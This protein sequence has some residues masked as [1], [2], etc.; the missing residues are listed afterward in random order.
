MSSSLPL[1]PLSQEELSAGTC[2]AITALQSSGLGE[3]EAALKLETAFAAWLDTDG[4]GDPIPSELHPLL[5]A[6]G[7]AGKLK[8]PAHATYA[9]LIRK[10]EGKYVAKRRDAAVLLSQLPLMLLLAGDFA[11]SPAR[12]AQLLGSM[13]GRNPMSWRVVQVVLVHFRIRNELDSELVEALIAEDEKAATIQFTDADVATILELF[14]EQSASFGL[15]A[16]FK[17]SLSSLLSPAQGQPFIPYLQILLYVSVVGHFYDHPPEYIY[18]FKP[19]GLVANLVF[20]KFPAQLAPGGN[21]ML[22]N[23][24]AL[25]RLTY[26]WAESREDNKIQAAALV[27][28]V[29]GLSSLSF[30]A[31]KQ[32]CGTIRRGIFRFVE[33][34]TPPE[35]TIPAA[36]DL[37]G[38]RTFLGNVAAEATGT[39]GII[40]QRVTDFLS[41]MRYRDTAWRARGLGDPVNASNTSSQKLGDCDFQ[42]AATHRY[43]AFK[44]HAG[45]LTDVYLE[46][47]LRTL[48]INLPKRKVEWS[49][50]SDIDEWSIVVTF[51]THE[52]ARSI[53]KAD[54]VDIPCRLMVETFSQ[55]TAALLDAV[56]DDPK[57]CVSFFN[58][59]VIAPLNAPNTPHYAKQKTLE[60]F[61]L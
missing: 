54:T 6:A 32:L 45:R 56:V 22:N 47:H 49:G 40:E 11:A 33:L 50:I 21:P 48:R 17:D 10:I 20:S 42:N 15:D 55:A 38:I 31:R 1:L 34:R 13:D 52:D 12:I 18:T 37:D 24:K 25:D 41:A 8:A 46:E 14:A 44:T 5:S 26:D 59:L 2:A 23:F 58:R 3:D 61:A 51:I 36:K 53:V 27:S 4:S 57:P 9:S 7:W 19:R 39:R 60:L 29:I 30:P 43:H 35:I 28:V 16:G